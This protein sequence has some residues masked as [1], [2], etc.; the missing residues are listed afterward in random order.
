M[1]HHFTFLTAVHKGSIF[2]V[3]LPAH[4]ILFCFFF[5]IVA[6]ITDV[7]WYLIFISLMICDVEHFFISLL[8]I[9]MSFLE[10]YLFKSF[11]QFLIGLFVFCYSVLSSLYILDVN[12]LQD[13][14]FE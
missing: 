9:C 6:I 7:K 5:S 13:I 11:A 2:S 14:W 3:T 4:V 12:P 1:L 10:M 8:A